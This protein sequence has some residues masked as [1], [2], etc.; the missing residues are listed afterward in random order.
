MADLPRIFARP[1]LPFQQLPQAPVDQTFGNLAAASAHLAET[2][3]RIDDASVEAESRRV[4][5]ETQQSI[6]GSIA[7]SE[8]KITDPEEFRATAT[9][10]SQAI[11]EAGLS[12]IKNPRVRQRYHD[13]LSPFLIGSSTTITLE[14]Q[15]KKVLESQGSAVKFLEGAERDLSVT[16]DPAKITQQFA[17]IDQFVNRMVETGSFKPS[18]G[19][20]ILNGIRERDSYR[21]AVR[22]VSISL[23]PLAAVE[24]IQKTFPNID[25]DKVL[26][27]LHTA[28]ERMT[29]IEKARKESEKKI[30]DESLLRDTIGVINGSLPIAMLGQTAIA[31]KYTPE[32]FNMLRRAAEEGG[33]TDPNVAMAL[34]LQIRQ[35]KLQDYGAIATNPN[36]DR[37]TRTRLMDLIE[38]Q[39]DAN[40][41]SKTPE[42]QEA[43]KEIRTA[44]SPKGMMES[45]D[46]TEQ[47]RFLFA[48]TELWNR[49]E[50]GES[51]MAVSRDLQSRI[52]REPTQGEKP[53]FVPRFQTEEQLINAFKTKQVD[54]KTFDTEANLL[55]QWGVYNKQNA[56][57]AAQPPAAGSTS[58]RRQ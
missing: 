58:R 7:E 3:N 44:V 52:A 5:Q 17:S 4:I 14:H 35:N 37:M 32:E 25:P 13:A 9:K 10:S 21:R 56:E 18:E 19:A 12:G 15:K 38:K 8:A 29:E 36:I 57:R 11:Y 23:D 39:K 55:K 43:S 48:T 1:E 22:V 28:H 47:Q 27:L 26:T 46:K 42:Y 53:L 45:F 49:V 20:K 31:R 30:H 33:I 24:D 34:E 51:P 41:F 16:L 2:F 6:H 54:R 40:H 50:K